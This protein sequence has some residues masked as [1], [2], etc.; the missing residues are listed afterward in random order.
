[1]SADPAGVRQGPTG[2]V[3]AAEAGDVPQILERIRGLA[4]YEREPDIVETTEQQLGEAL[5]GPSPSVF[6]HV[7]DEGGR[8]EGVAIWFVNYSTWTGRHGIFLEDLFVSPDARGKGYG[9]ALMRA[10]AA[11][12]VERGYSRLDWSVLDWNEPSIGFYRSLGAHHLSD[13]QSYR[14]AGAALEALAASA[15]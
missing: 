4:E 14:L 11:L 8:I 9:R 3:R 1:M 15:S 10:L 2:F 5:F 13:W 7:V 12:C 6:A